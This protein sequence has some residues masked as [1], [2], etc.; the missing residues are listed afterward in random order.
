M[1]LDDQ[2]RYPSYRIRTVGHARHP[3]RLSVRIRSR[4]PDSI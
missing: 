2:T 3:L 1:I 4:L